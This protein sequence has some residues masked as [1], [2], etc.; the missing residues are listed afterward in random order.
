MRTT[1]HYIL[2]LFRSTLEEPN[3]QEHDNFFAWGGTSLMAVEMTVAVN[4]QYSLAVDESLLLLNPSPAEYAQ[5]IAVI[6]S[7]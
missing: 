4:S 1:L 7:T 2:E 3:L 5:A 6:I